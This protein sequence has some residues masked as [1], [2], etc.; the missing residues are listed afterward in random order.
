[1]KRLYLT[2]YFTDSKIDHQNHLRVI[3]IIVLLIF[4][5]LSLSNVSH[6][7]TTIFYENFSNYPDGTTAGTDWYTDA[8]DCDDASPNEGLGISTFGVYGGVFTANDSEGAPCCPLGGGGGQ[9]YVYMGPFDISDYCRIVFE[10]TIGYS[11][12]LECTFDPPFFDCQGTTPP[13]NYY[14]Q[15]VEEFSIDG[16]PYQLGSYGCA[17][18]GTQYSLFYLDIPPSSTIM[19]RISLANNADDEY[20]YIHS[21]KYTGISN[22]ETTFNPIGPICENADPIPLPN[23][24]TNGISG[25]W[26]VGPFFDPSG[27]GGTTVP[28][29]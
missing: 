14:D 25:T 9:N 5:L 20:S 16:G 18:G 28:I 10:K 13:D 29:I 7:Q 26:D 22:V 23:S 11:L 8:T 4:Q 21:V 2:S 1:M 19:F 27:L 6:S 3:K 24:S 15:Y 12:N 17:Q